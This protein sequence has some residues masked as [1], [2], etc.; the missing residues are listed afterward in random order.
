MKNPN[1]L[2]YKEKLFFKVGMGI[3]PQL[4]GEEVTKMKKPF[5]VISSG[6]SGTTSFGVGGMFSIRN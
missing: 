4:R 1:H 2:I 6:S 5:E 3:A